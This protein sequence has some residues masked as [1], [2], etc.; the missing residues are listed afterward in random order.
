MEEPISA[1]EKIFVIRK[2][3]IKMIMKRFVRVCKLICRGFVLK[4]TDDMNTY[5]AFVKKVIACIWFSLV[6]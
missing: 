3:A 5:E 4:M 6:V 1:A 2:N